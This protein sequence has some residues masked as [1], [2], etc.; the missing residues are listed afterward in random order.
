MRGLDGNVGTRVLCTLTD[1]S[2]VG[3]ASMHTPCPPTVFF[4]LFCHI[5]F[6]LTQNLC[7]RQKREIGLLRMPEAKAK[8]SH[9][10]QHVGV[11][12]AVVVESCR[13]WRPVYLRGGL[14]YPDVTSLLPWFRSEETGIAFLPFSRFSSFFL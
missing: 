7:Y 2:R 6:S 5:L 3:W 1:T 4:L 8:K 10:A 13:K 12:H 9:G 11:P 14:L